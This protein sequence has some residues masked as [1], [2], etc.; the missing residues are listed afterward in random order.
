MSS[1]EQSPT[2]ECEMPV[3]GNSGGRRVWS[4]V[5]ATSALPVLLLALLPSSSGEIKP[6]PD[7][8]DL[9]LSA[10]R[11]APLFG[12]RLSGWKPQIRNP[13]F[14]FARTMFDREAATGGS[15]PE[16]QLFVG[17]YS[18]E[19]QRHRA[20][21]IQYWNRTYDHEKWMPENFFK[22][23]SPSGLPLQGITLRSFSSGK[24]VHLAYTYY[25]AG[26]WETD[27]WR[28]KFAQVAS[29]FSARKDASLIIFG[30][31]CEDCDGRTVVSDLVSDV[32]PSIVNQVDQKFQMGVE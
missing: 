17:V 24:R 21:L 19:Y 7:P 9:A 13:D 20:E 6:S 15:G 8:L 12:N 23:V 1:S 2:P 3:L 14:V 28:A 18:Y 31:A 32:M 30:A 27:Q 22:V 25:V 16:Q 4:G 11:Y 29:F 26:L 10:E 5:A